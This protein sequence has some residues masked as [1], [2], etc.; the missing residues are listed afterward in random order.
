MDFEILC[1][2]FLDPELA[3]SVKPGFRARFS[4]EL[5][6]HSVLFNQFW[7]TRDI[8]NKFTGRCSS[9]NIQGNKIKHIQ[10]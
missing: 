6:L 5:V 2:R 4:K 1:S 9:I 8:C 3:Y 10:C 7:F